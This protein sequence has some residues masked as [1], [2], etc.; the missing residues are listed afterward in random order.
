MSVYPAG[1]QHRFTVS[2]FPQC[3]TDSR[4]NSQPPLGLQRLKPFVWT[5]RSLVESPWLQHLMRTSYVI[6]LNMCFVYLARQSCIYMLLGRSTMKWSTSKGRPPRVTSA[7]CKASGKQ[8][9]RVAVTSCQVKKCYMTLVRSV[10]FFFFLDPPLYF[11]SFSIVPW[12][13]KTKPA[14]MNVDCMIV[15]S[16]YFSQRFSVAR[17]QLAKIAAK[18]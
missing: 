7:N 12:K 14:S 15:P 3:D 1:D 10:S 18:L 13:N 16:F 9:E 6:D 11:S 17:R 8:D 5:S 2:L 4:E